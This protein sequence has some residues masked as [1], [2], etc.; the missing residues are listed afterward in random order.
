MIGT[1]N[2]RSVRHVE[3]NRTQKGPFPILL[4]TFSLCASSL[5]SFFVTRMMI[6]LTDFVEST[7]RRCQSLHQAIV[8]EIPVERVAFEIKSKIDSERRGLSRSYTV[9]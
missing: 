3:E 9:K 7:S 4:R 5:T 6:R 8:D 2:V 1:G